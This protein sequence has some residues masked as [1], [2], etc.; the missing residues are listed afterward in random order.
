MGDFVDSNNNREVT[1]TERAK[2]VIYQ[3]P[4][5]PRH[6]MWT[7]RWDAPGDLVETGMDSMRRTY[8]QDAVHIAPIDRQPLNSTFYQT[9]LVRTK[10]GNTYLFRRGLMANANER[11]VTDLEKAG[12][13][14]EAPRIRIGEPL[15]L[16]FREG[17][18]QHTSDVVSVEVQIIDGII[19]DWFRGGVEHVDNP[20]AWLKIVQNLDRIRNASNVSKLKLL[21][22]DS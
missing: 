1:T 9:V 20:P 5:D 14:T 6:S 17:G 11:Q 4:D 21:H 18:R 8:R 22:L 3:D 12:G 2:L 15:S 16:D 13:L 7:A 19:E 10:S